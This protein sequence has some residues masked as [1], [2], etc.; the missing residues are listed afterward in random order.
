[1]AI[2]EK[3][4][5]LADSPEL[6]ARMSAASAERIRSISSLEETGRK[7]VEVLRNAV[8]QFRT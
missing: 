2:A 4:Q 6:R 8:Y 3:L 1:M 7:L 5:M